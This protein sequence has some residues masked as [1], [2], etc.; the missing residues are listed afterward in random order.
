M[1]DEKGLH[2]SANQGGEVTLSRALVTLSSV[3]LLPCPS[4]TGQLLRWLSPIGSAWAHGVTTPRRLG[5][6]NVIDLRAEQ[7]RLV[8]LGQLLPP[9]GRYCQARVTFG[10]IDADGA[11]ASGFP[12]MKG[13]SMDLVGEIRTSVT[14]S[15]VPIALRSQA[16]VGVEVDLH[17]RSFVGGASEDL[18]FELP[19][20]GVFEGVDTA[21]NDAAGEVLAR[22]AAAARA[23]P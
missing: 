6:P 14:A 10:P 17:E 12:E 1:L 8:T 3:E 16:V 19:L 4:A 21:S 9:A 2:L 13:S 23:M 7:G 20:A 18:T 22:V 15:S 5:V 11:V